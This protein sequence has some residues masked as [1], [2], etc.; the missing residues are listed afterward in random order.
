MRGYDRQR[1]T[2][3]LLKRNGELQM[4][5]VPLIDMP[6]NMHWNVTV[7]YKLN[8]TFEYLY[9]TDDALYGFMLQVHEFS[10]QFTG[11]FF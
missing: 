9:K 10:L 2:H 7:Y 6:G 5:Q 8:Y 4:I 11:W 3:L 1:L